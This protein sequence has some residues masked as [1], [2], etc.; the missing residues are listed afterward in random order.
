[1]KNC[2]KCDTTKPLS[3]FYTRR[4]EQTH[5][6]CKPCVNKQTIDRQRNLK[7]KAI[8][9]KGGFCQDCKGIFHPAVY[10]FHHINPDEKDFSLAH[11]KA[12]KWSDEI[13]NELDKCILLCSNCHRLRHAKY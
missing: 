1:M 12:L 8:E 2:P 6:Y 4:G 13:T 3:E 10:D 7:R 9:Y 11:H 5:S